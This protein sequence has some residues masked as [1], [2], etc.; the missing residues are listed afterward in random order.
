LVAGASEVVDE[1]REVEADVIVAAAGPGNGRRWLSTVRRPRKKRQMGN[2]RCWLGQGV[3]ASDDRVGEYRE[4]GS[5]LVEVEA[6]AE[7]RRAVAYGRWRR[8]SALRAD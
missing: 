4:T 6:S 5:E 2:R 8:R 7:P 1:V 3:D